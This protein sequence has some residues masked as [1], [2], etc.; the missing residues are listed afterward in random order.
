LQIKTAII[1][2]KIAI[3]IDYSQNISCAIAFNRQLKTM[4]WHTLSR[5]FDET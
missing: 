5:F 3:S 2:E 1:A 4:A